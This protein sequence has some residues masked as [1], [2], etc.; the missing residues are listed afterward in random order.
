MRNVL[1]ALLVL[2]L[3]APS[4]VWADGF[5]FDGEGI[6]N[7]TIED[8]I[9]ANRS[10]PA[11]SGTLDSIK[12]WLTVTT[13]A[14][15]VKLAVYQWS[16][17]SF[18]DST[19]II[20]VPVGEGWVYF[21]FVNNNSITASTEY[22]LAVVAEQTAGD[23]KLDLALTGVHAGDL[24]SGYGEWQTPKWTTVNHTGTW[25]FSIYCFYTPEAAA[26]AFIMIH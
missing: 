16:D 19:E 5:G 25:K 12:A 17:T 6:A 21:E 24:N 22:V 18:V 1:A 20:D 4:T 3:Y 23:C 10:S 8:T 11:S 9:W 7:T 26:G 2:M 14:H 15:L 13:E